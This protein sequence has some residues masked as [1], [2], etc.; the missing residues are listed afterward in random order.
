MF[1]WI[2]TIFIFVAVI[3]I[4]ALLFGGWLIVVIVSA[5]GRLLM[6]P[7]RARTKSPRAI[8]AGEVT[9]PRCANERCRAENPPIAS[10]CRRC[11]SPV[12]N[13]QHVPV[14]R[15]AMW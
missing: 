14:R 3:A 12:R 1:E 7:F 10:F 13:A 6:L 8:I 11:G 9:P 15:V 4:T 2:V 5:L